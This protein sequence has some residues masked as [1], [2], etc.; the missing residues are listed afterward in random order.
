[1]TYYQRIMEDFAASYTDDLKAICVKYSK[2]I[3]KYCQHPQRDGHYT[4]REFQQKILYELE[5][6]GVARQHESQRS[7]WLFFIRD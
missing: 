3:A 6:R 4:S 5:S 7:Y 1:M 2:L